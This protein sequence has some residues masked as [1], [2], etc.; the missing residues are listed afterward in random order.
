MV[1]TDCAFET[2]RLAARGWHAVAFEG[3]RGRG[4][5]DVVAEL[6]TPAVTRT[7]PPQWSGAYSVDRARAKKQQEAFREAAK[8]AKNTTFTRRATRPKKRSR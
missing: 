3:A 2:E 6:L 7:L 1:L 5:A 8:R 4:L